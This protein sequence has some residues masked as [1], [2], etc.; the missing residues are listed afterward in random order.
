MAVALY[1]NAKTFVVYII[2]LLAPVIQV[3]HS[4]QVQLRLLLADKAPIK[5]PP[6]YLDYANIFLFD[7][8]IELP[9]NTS[10]NEYAIKLVEDK[11]LLYRP[12]YSLRLVK[13]EILKTYIKT[14]LKTEFI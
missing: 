5:V 3:Y 7:L 12:I 4:C 8:E 1:D 11:Q 9:K 10:I 6:K 13:L 14:H 2:T